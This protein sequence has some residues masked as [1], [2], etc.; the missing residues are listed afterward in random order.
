MNH[1][2][3]G[4][5]LEVFEVPS[6]VLFGPNAIE[7]LPE[8]ISSYFSFARRIIILTGKVRSRVYAEKIASELSN[9]VIDVVTVSG[10]SVDE[11]LELREH[12]ARRNV[13]LVVCVG[14]GRVIDTGKALAFLL[15]VPLISVPTTAS[16]DGFASPYV[17]Y[18]F[19]YELSRRGIPK[20]RKT[21]SA[22]V[23]DTSII[24]KAPRRFLV[25]GIGELLGKIVAVKDWELAHKVKGEDF[26]EFAAKLSQSSFE[27][28]VKNADK[29]SVHTEEAVRI[30]VKA[31]I[32]C[33]V[34]MA[35]AGSSRPCSGSEH[36]FCHALDLVLYEHGQEPALHGEQVALGTIMMAYLHGLNWR[37]LKKLMI[38][39]QV[40]TT[41]RELGLDRDVILE[42][43][44]RAHK[45]RPDR[46]TILGSDGLTRKAAERLI[47]ITGVA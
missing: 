40:P 4:K 12:S 18:L 43:L 32:G 19:Q 26:S 24:L 23:A 21:P 2:L 47:E 31:L 33:G 30:V 27:L 42:A 38:K 9:A 22:I 25:S 3:S 16:H 14:G 35:I 13:D 7:R 36:M 45:I 41:A 39:L 6:R 28:V 44:L 5:G 46:Y 20:I 34:A 37:R 8:L 15:N 11:V 17:S 10:C 1:L 29:L